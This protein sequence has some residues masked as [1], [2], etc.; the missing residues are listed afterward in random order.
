MASAFLAQKV[1]IQLSSFS[2]HLL[3]SFVEESMLMLLLRLI[4]D[5][6]HLKSMGFGPPLIIVMFLYLTI[7]VCVGCSCITKATN[8]RGYGG[9]RSNAVSGTKLSSKSG[10]YTVYSLGN[11]AF[12]G[13][14]AKE[15]AK[16][17][18]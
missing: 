15:C 17:A 11:F 12:Y 13:P 5:H 16:D 1:E 7:Y 6:L 4:N 3:I 9:R 14:V 10:E 18:R 2:H 8:T